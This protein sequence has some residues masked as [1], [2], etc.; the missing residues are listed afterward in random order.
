MISNLRFRDSSRDVLIQLADIIAGSINRK[1]QK[2]KADCEKYWDII[3]CKKEDL[4][5][6]K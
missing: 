1:Y 5:V 3:K 6:F 4:W 2:D